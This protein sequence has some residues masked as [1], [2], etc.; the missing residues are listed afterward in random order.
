MGILG[1]RLAA[2]QQAAGICRLA[3]FTPNQLAKVE[4]GT[5]KTGMGIVSRR[6]REPREKFGHSL[7]CKMGLNPHLFKAGAGGG[8]V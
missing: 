6:T 5:L 1:K 8:E 7:T 2:F 3:G 4:S